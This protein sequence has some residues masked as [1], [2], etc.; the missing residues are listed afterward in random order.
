[1]VLALLT[2]QQL[3]GIYPTIFYA[4][5]LFQ[6][7]RSNVIEFRPTTVTASYNLTTVAN[8]SNVLNAF[9]FTNTSLQL[10]NATNVTSTTPVPS[11]HVAG[12][13]ELTN[14]A[15]L[16]LMSLGCIRFVVSI[17]MTMLSKKFGVRSLLIFSSFG[18]G[19]SSVAF[20]FHQVGWCSQSSDTVSF[21]IILCF[22]TFGSLGLMVI[23][24]TLVGE[25]LPMEFRGVGQGIS[26][27]YAFVVMFFVVKFYPFIEDELGTSLVFL[28]FGSVAFVTVGFVYFFVPDTLG[29][30]MDE[31]QKFFV[32]R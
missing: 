17:V 20:A 31:I 22:I 13:L 14:P 7:V 30:T 28:I 29:K 11:S 3:V 4:L 6:K 2:L 25:V 5:E 16:A 8:A 19:V 10:T 24:W 27:A 9:N 21:A 18:I 23:P 26:V 12:K 15:V 32:K 1:M